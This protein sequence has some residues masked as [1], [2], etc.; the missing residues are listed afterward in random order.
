MKKT[1]I[2]TG[3]TGGI[4]EALCDVFARG[5]YAVAAVYAKNDSKAEELR[6]KFGDEDFLC[7]KADISVPDGAKAV[8]DAAVPKFGEPDTVINNAG[9]SGVGLLQC[10]SDD[11]IKKIID[12]DLMSVIYMC[13]QAAEHMVKIH[14]GNIINVSS[15]WGEVGAS[16]EAVYSAAKAGVIGLTKALAKE[17]GPSGIRVNCLS[18]GFIDTPMNSCFGEDVRVEIADETPLCRIGTPREAAECAYFLASDSAAFVT[19]QILGVNGGLV[20]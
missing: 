17:L 20:I 7:I 8:F 19:G 16:T 12:T 4:G 11:E 6:Q 5:G 13:R 14:R 9:I 3:A 10:M 18:P 15:M 1:A 2:I